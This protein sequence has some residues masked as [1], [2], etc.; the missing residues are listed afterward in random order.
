M[1]LEINWSINALNDLNK[2]QSYLS[3]SKIDAIYNAPK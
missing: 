3:N 1:S 2:L